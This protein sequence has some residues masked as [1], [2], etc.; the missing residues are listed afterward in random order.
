MYGN[1]CKFRDGVKPCEYDRR[2]KAEAARRRKHSRYDSVGKHKKMEKYD[3][4]N[5][6]VRF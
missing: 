6:K 4:S 2:D 5:R 1:H 3:K